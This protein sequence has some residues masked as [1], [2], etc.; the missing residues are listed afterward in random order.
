MIAHVHMHVFARAC[1]FTIASPGSSHCVDKE[2][3]RLNAVLS[4]KV[5]TF[6]LASEPEISLDGRSRKQGS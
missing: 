3:C 2:D 6:R 1:S 4:D 5:I